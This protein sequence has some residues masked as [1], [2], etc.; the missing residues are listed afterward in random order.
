MTKSTETKRYSIISDFM[1]DHTRIIT[2]ALMY[3]M[4]A[5]LGSMV[6]MSLK[7]KPTTTIAQLTDMIDVERQNRV[8][9]LNELEQKQQLIDALNVSVM[10]ARSD[11]IEYKVDRARYEV[12]IHNYS[13]LYEILKRLDLGAAQRFAHRAKIQEEALSK[14]SP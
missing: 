3:V 7:E 6:G 2:I 4:A 8:R 13:A 12:M 14:T 5:V 1:G 10:E 11:N 9:L